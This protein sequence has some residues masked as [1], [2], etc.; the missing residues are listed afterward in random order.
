MSFE[1][2]AAAAQN[3]ELVPPGMEPGLEFHAN[4]DL[5]ANPFSFGAH[6]AVVEI[7]RDTGALRFLRY[8]AVHDCGPVINPKLIEGQVHGAIA[9][10]L[11][12]A[13]SEVVAY[14]DD[15]QPLN[16]TFMDYAIPKAVDMPD[17]E[18][19]F[20]ETPS[21]T[22]P[23]G[24]KGIGE[25]PTVASPVAV[26]NAVND[27][28]SRLGVGQIDAPLTPEKIWQALHP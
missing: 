11:G 13:R 4:F 5:E 16:G 1:D 6:I 8:A 28:L 9:Q 18:L 3:P 24:V 26:A 27:A 21:P 14:D 17:L 2:V 23:L 22:N 20:T 19:D 12:Q 7:D 10:G 25:L 15:G